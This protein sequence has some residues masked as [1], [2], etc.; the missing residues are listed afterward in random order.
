MFLKRKYTAIGWL[1]TGCVVS[2][3]NCYYRPKAIKGLL[4][5]ITV[6]GSLKWANSN[7]RYCTCTN[8]MTRFKLLKKILR[9][10]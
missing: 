6:F 5:F 9:A 8:Q 7:E 4:D 3:S 2:L 10:V 1:A